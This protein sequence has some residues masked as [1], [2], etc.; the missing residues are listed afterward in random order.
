MSIHIC[1]F[2]RIY[3]HT[4]YDYIKS[5]Y[6]YTAYK[7]I[8]T[9][10]FLVFLVNDQTLTLIYGEYMGAKKRN[11]NVSKSSKFTGALHHAVATI[12][13]KQNLYISLCVINHRPYHTHK[14]LRLLTFT[15]NRGHGGAT[16]SSFIGK[17][18][19]V[20]DRPRQFSKERISSWVSQALYLS[21]TLCCLSNSNE[22]STHNRHV[23]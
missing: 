23:M 20:K 22:L 10:Y 19:T 5:I 11:W 6:L 9:M 14:W 17:R 15:S 21:P 8:C 16:T 12:K 4:L 2:I 18:V 13:K 3:S 1:A 7:Y